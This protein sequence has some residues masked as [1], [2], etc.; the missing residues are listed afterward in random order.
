MKGILDFGLNMLLWFFYYHT[1][2]NTFSSPNVINYH[3]FVVNTVIYV[4]PYIFSVICILWENENKVKK[5]I[6]NFI[7][8]C[9]IM[10]CLFFFS[11][12]S[13]E[14]ILQNRTA[15][16]LKIGIPGLFILIESL[17]INTYAKCLLVFPILNYL[18][19][20]ILKGLNRKEEKK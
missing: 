18:M 6:L 7:G 4:A 16:D 19:M 14:F 12:I 10:V 11:G 20:P 5:Y 3:N 1:T 15:E 2:L 13:L 8:I 9:Y 17:T